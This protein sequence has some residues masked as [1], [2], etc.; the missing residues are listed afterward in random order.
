MN[1]FKILKCQMVT[2]KPF[3]FEA[4]KCSVASLVF[5][6]GCSLIFTI[7]KSDVQWIWGLNDVRE[8]FLI[9]TNYVHL[10]FLKL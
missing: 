4:S 6:K 10:T 7:G 8:F 9:P 3:H 5:I 2:S 1:K